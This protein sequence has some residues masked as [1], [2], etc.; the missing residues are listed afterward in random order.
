MESW[1]HDPTGNWHG[2]N[3]AYPMCFKSNQKFGWQ[4]LLKTREGSVLEYVI[5][6]GAERNAATSGLWRL[7]F[8]QSSAG[9]RTKKANES[10][11]AGTR[12]KPWAK[13]SGT[14]TLDQNRQHTVVNEIDSISET[15]G[16]SWPTPDHDEDGNMTEIPR[17]LSLTDRFDLKWDSWNRLLAVSAGKQGDRRGRR[18][19]FR[20][21]QLIPE[22]VFQ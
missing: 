14:T 10:T 13:E 20:G 12:L 17:P 22:N 7:G 18:N 21:I 4:G 2:E 6:R 8:R 19:G 11:L 3:T 1:N 9:L 5:K 16:P 15:T